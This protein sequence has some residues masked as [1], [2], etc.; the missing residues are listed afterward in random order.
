[1]NDREK[2]K[3]E[4][5]ASEMKKR[6]KAREK[7]EAERLKKEISL[8]APEDFFKKH[9]KWNDQFAT[10]DETGFPLTTTDGKPLSKGLVKRA[11]KALQLHK[12]S[13]GKN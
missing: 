13:Q 2:R 11:T 12:K 7:A 1:M 9:P 4:R 6:E 3:I 10:Y 8:I 5:F